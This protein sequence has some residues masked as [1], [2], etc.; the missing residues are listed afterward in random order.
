MRPT[1]AWDQELVMHTGQTKSNDQVNIEYD[2]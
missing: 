2:Y 1:D